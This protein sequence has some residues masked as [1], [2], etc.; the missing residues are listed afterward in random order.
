MHEKLDETRFDPENGV[1][2]CQCGWKGAEKAMVSLVATIHP[3]SSVVADSCISRG[4]VVSVAHGSICCAMV[5]VVLMIR[6][7]QRP[8]HVT[9]VF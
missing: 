3:L 9:I 4:N 1:V 7:F 2:N 8:M 5:L 6:G